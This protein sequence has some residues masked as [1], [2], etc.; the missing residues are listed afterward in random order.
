MGSFAMTCAVSG[1]PI[2]YGNPIRFSLL[3]ENPYNSSLKCSM[4]D[5]WFPRTWPIKATYNDYGSVENYTMGESWLEGLKVD[6][7]PVGVGE[8]QIHDVATSKNMTFDEMLTA[9]WEGRIRVKRRVDYTS[10]SLSKI[11]KIL[12]KYKDVK[13]SKK[14]LPPGIPTLRRISNLL[15]RAGFQVNTGGWSNGLRVNVLRYGNV[16]VR[17]EEKDLVKAE[18]ILCA[19]YATMLRAGEGSYS[20]GHTEI[21]V[22]PK[23]NTKGFHAVEP[24][25]KK[26]LLVQGMMIR[27]DVW[28]AICTLPTPIGPT[29]P[30]AFYKGALSEWDSLTGN[31]AETNKLAYVFS[32]NEIPFSMGLG[33]DFFL[34]SKSLKGPTEKE[35]FLLGAAEFAY[36]RMY[37]G[38]IRHMWMPSYSVGPQFGE[39]KAHTAYLQAMTR[40]SRANNKGQK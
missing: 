6:L 23:P 39:W 27:E 3:T 30:V 38:S 20:H 33:N 34:K 24:E 36:I 29:G 16:R 35:E 11:D 31:Q 8:N 22:C 37:L 4:H 14:V 5:S 15:S 1:L 26:R 17:G 25:S 9:L 2:E 19:E 18:R 12:E 32:S 21:L 10:R 28:Q 40:V 7:K 13:P